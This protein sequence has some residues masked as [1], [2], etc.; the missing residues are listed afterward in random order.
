MKKSLLFLLAPAA[1]LSFAAAAA[2]AHADSGTSYQ[3]T[4]AA[5]NGSGASGTFMLSLNGS[6]ATISEHVTG[7]AA[8]FSGAAYPH[9]QHI[10]GGAM[11]VCP[12]TSADT[13]K[14]GVISTTE[15]APS[16]GG[17][18][19]T[20]STSGD[21][22]PAAGTNLKTAPSGGSY[23]YSR[24]IT[25]DS[26]T[27]ASLKAGTAVVVVHGLDPTTLSAAAQAEKSDLVPSLPL[28]ATSPTL[29]GKVLASQVTGMPNGGVATGGGSTAGL[30]NE[31]LLAAGGVMLL[32]AGALVGAR[33]RLTAKR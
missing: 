2:P 33:R 30:Q 15:G 27:V 12:T 7:V 22:T 23:D 25:L 8:T 20:L 6:T 4:L 10:H 1:A 26:A 21:T 29:C 19:T 9:V 32:G 13:N 18:L 11:G 31:G 5:I 28:A 16:Y 3:A 17:I 14:D 24:T